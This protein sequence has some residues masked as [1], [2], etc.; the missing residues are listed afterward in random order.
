MFFPKRAA[1]KRKPSRFPFTAVPLFTSLLLLS[2]TGRAGLRTANGLSL[3]GPGPL[4][5]NTP[6]GFNPSLLP[7]GTIPWFRRSLPL[8][9]S[10]LFS[11]LL[12]TVSKGSQAFPQAVIPPVGVGHGSGRRQVEGVLLIHIFFV[13]VHRHHLGQKH[14]MASQLIHPHHPALQVHRTF[15]DQRH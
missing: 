11:R 10:A 2:Y 12:H 3:P 1:A 15:P 14:M 6:S 5:P 4:S 9:G 7:S 13:H 8:P